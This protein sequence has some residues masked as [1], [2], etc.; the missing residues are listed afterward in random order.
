MASV[1]RSL[2]FYVVFYLMSVIF[3]ILTVIAARLIGQRFMVIGDSWSR[4][5]R[6]CVRYILGIKI[7]E[8]GARPPGAVLYAVKHESFFDAIDLP[9][10]LPRPVVFAK[11]ELF[12]VPGW[13]RALRVYGGVPVA[14][15]DGAKALRYMISEARRLAK[16]GRPMAIFPEGSRVAHGKQPQLKAGFAG[17]YKVLKLPVVPVAIDSGV[18]YHRRWKKRGTITLRF[19]E[20]IPPGLPR[21][22]VEVL[23]HAGINAL[24]PLD[25]K[26][27]G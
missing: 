21:A 10:S 13:G 20:V 8:E 18:L 9:S 4:F 15:S 26:A 14:R 12:Q 16:T 7:C 24:N 5:H 22:E 19:G 6:L 27:A 1:I 17:I 25:E 3:V 2:V 11:E 23:V